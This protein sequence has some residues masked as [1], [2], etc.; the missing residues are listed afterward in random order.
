MSETTAPAVKNNN[1]RKPIVC[2]FPLLFDVHI[3][4]NN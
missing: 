3:Q 2:H 4:N 1:Q